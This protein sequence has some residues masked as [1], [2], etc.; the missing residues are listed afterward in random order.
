M[1]G[2]RTHDPG[3]RVSEDTVHALD[4]AATVT[5]YIT[6]IMSKNNLKLNSHSVKNR[7]TIEKETRLSLENKR[8]RKD[9]Q[10]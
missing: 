4:R 2:I 1:V 9:S 5:G 8:R 6:S 10:I 7:K 3:V